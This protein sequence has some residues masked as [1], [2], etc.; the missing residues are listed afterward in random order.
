MVSIK[1]FSNVNLVS[2][3]TSEAFLKKGCNTYLV[4]Y[5]TGCRCDGMSA[6]ATFVLNGFV[7]LPQQP[8]GNPEVL[9]FLAHT[10]IKIFAGICR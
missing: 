4:I 8:S 9:N 10:R 5:K 2:G 3:G 7:K 6:F 1:L